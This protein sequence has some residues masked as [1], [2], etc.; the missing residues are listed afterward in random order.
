MK[1][2]LYDRCLYTLIL[3]SHD[4]GNAFGSGGHELGGVTVSVQEP[5]VFHLQGM[6]HNSRVASR[7]RK[8]SRCSLEV[9]V[10][11]ASGSHRG[12]WL[13]RGLDPQDVCVCKQV[14]PQSKRLLNP[15]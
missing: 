6:E 14:L 9:M 8:K 10:G 5:V 11:R 7:K 13:L 3:E 15:N 4:V 2:R 12:S 1:H